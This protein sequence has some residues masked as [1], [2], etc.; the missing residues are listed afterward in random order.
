MNP[1]LDQELVD[2][3]IALALRRYPVGEAIVAALRTNSGKILTSVCAQARVDSANLCA[4]TGSIC[5]AHK[6]DESVVASACLYRESELFPFRV[7]PACGIC[8]ERLAYWGLNVQ[9]AVPLNEVGNEKIWQAKTLR[10]LR[11]FYWREAV[12]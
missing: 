12:D 6:I 2:A 9:I 4:E 3:A 1:A 8:Q 11:P 7:L 10:Q 5:E